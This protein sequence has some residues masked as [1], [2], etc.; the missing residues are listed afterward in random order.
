VPVLPARV[1]GVGAILGLQVGAVLQS[2]PEAWPGS[3]NF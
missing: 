3:W 2:P 1:P